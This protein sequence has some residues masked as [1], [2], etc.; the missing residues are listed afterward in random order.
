MIIMVNDQKKNRFVPD[1]AIPPGAS[2][3]DELKAIGMPQKEL[4]KRMGTSIK[5]VNE[6]IKGRA[7]LT[8]D[9]AIKL[10]K[11]LGVPASFWVN[12]ESNYQITLARIR[13]KR[14]I[15]AQESVAKTF[16]YAEMAKLGWVK[17]TRSIEEKIDELCRYLGFASLT[18]FRPEITASFRTGM[19]YRPSAEALTAWLRK[20][21]LDA[22]EITTANYNSKIFKEALTSIRKI[23]C[24]PGDDFSSRI[25]A[26]CASA[27]VAVVFVPHLKGTYANGATWWI[28]PQKAIILLSIRGRYEDIFWFSFFHEAGHLALGHSK[29]NKFIDFE[30][31][32]GNTYERQA[33]KFASD[34]MIPPGKYSSFLSQHDFSSKSINS[35][36]KDIG[37]FPSIVVGRLQHDKIIGYSDLHRLRSKLIW[38]E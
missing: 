7:P 27:G 3:L 37:I 19:Q 4:A 9:T 6:L 11:I 33:N 17:K 18:S 34:F 28:T 29:K 30:K 22:Q 31:F 2:L 24:K 25:Q 5:M 26:I 38:K 32:I 10:E 15:A 16:P 36:A 1:L 8:Y 13:A 12:L 14:N 21:E 35:F 20:G 23:T